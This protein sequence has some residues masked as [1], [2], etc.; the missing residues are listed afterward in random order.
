MYLKPCRD[1]KRHK[2][3][4]YF[5]LRVHWCRKKVES[6]NG[7]FVLMYKF[8]F[9]HKMLKYF[10]GV[11]LQVYN[12]TCKTTPVK[13]WTWALMTDVCTCSRFLRGAELGRAQ[14]QTNTNRLVS[15]LDF[16]VKPHSE[17]ADTHP[18]QAALRGCWE[19]HGPGGVGP[20]RAEGRGCEGERKRYTTCASVLPPGDVLFWKVTTVTC[21][22]VTSLP[23]STMHHDAFTEIWTWNTKTAV[24]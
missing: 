8:N 6:E 22:Q 9:Q 4:H 16:V 7:C 18:G 1:T 23:V 13:S 3:F 21:D 17:C 19:I 12:Y 15:S 24:F 14:L 10:T 5:L 2:Q 20:C 11:V